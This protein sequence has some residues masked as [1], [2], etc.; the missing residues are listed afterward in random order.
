MWRS[1]DVDIVV[2]NVHLTLKEYTMIRM[3]ADGCKNRE[4]ASEIG[5]TEHV[6]KNYLRVLYDK[7]G[8]NTRLEIAL[9]FVSNNGYQANILGKRQAAGGGLP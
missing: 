5:T 3:I 9:W 6:V 7:V 1:C 2:G 4:I 8:M